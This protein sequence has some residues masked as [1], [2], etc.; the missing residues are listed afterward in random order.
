MIGTWLMQQTFFCI[1]GTF[2]FLAWGTLTWAEDLPKK[3]DNQVPTAKHNRDAHLVEEQGA[4]IAFNGLLLGGIVKGQ[5]VSADDLQNKKEYSLYR[6]QGKEQYSVY[7]AQG[8]EGMGQ[9]GPLRSENLKK[10]PDADFD[11]WDAIPEFDITMANGTVYKSDSA[12]LALTG[13]WNAVPRLAT[14]LDTQNATYRKVVHDFL[15]ENGLPNAKVHIMQLFK[16][17]LDGDGTDEVIISAQNSVSAD[18]KAAAWEVDKPL[19]L[20]LGGDFPTGSKKGHYS[21]VLVRKMVDAQAMTIPLC[22]FI[23][24]KDGMSD[25]LEWNPPFLHKIYQFADV[26]GDG[27]MEILLGEHFYEGYSYRVYAIQG[28]KAVQV[29]ENGFGV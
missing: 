25:D 7:S 19:P 4:V 1:I 13:K 11:P 26:D 2:F 6:V 23:A 10:E 18:N 5:W 28:N 17:D 21:V 9:G 24:L 15:A 16:V 3:S 29:L 27:I 12:R 14:K 8:Y 22:S 20:P